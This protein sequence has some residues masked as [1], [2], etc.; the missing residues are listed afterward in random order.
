M[1]EF[2]IY[3]D[4]FRGLNLTMNEK[5]LLSIYRYFTIKGEK[6]CCMMTNRELAKELEINEVYFSKLKKGLKEKGLIKT[7]GGIRVK[8][9]GVRKT[10]NFEEKDELKSYI[11]KRVK[12]VNDNFEPSN[13]ELFDKEIGDIWNSS[14]LTNKNVRVIFE[15]ILSDI[16]DKIINGYKELVLDSDGLLNEILKIDPK[17]ERSKYVIFQTKNWCSNKYDGN[18]KK[19]SKKVFSN[20][21]IHRYALELKRVIELNN[22]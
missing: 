4:E 15:D 7:D 5:A 18:I 3:N 20:Y 8:Y 2:C 10:I 14:T 22:E 21:D 9:I 16:V 19:A 6:K 11:L 17:I 1:K 12:E 13:I